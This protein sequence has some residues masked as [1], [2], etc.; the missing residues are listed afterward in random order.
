MKLIHIKKE[1][2]ISYEITPYAFRSRFTM[3]EKTAIYSHADQDILIRI[4]LDDISSSKMI[5]LNLPE[6]QQGMEYLVSKEIL[7][8]ERK[9]E[10]LEVV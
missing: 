8:E 9:N 2:P 10:I 4:F 6:L 3:E 1:K 5:I 7:T